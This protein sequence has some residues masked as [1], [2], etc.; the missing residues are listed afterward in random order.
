M[1]FTPQRMKCLHSM[2][3]FGE[4][5]TGG[6]GDGEFQSEGWGGGGLLLAIM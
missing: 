1:K 6:H 2:W 3:R 5:Y 4:F